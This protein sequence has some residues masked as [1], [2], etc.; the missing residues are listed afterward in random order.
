MPNKADC[1]DGT[2]GR[3]PCDQPRARPSPSPGGPTLVFLAERRI[4]TQ[5]RSSSAGGRAKQLADHLASHVRVR[6]NSLDAPLVI[7]IIGP[8]GAGKSTVFNTLAGRP[9]SRTGVLRP[10]TRV[11]VLCVHPDDREPLLDG[12][13][14]G[15]PLDH[16]NLIEDETI[17]PGLA[18][19]DAPDI[20]SIEHANRNLADRFVEAADL[21][22]FVT[23]AT[24]YADQVPW[25]V[26]ER[27]RQRGLPL[28]FIVNCMPPDAADRGEVIRDVRRLLVEAG[29][30]DA[31][32]GG[33]MARAP[34]SEVRSS[35]ARTNDADGAGID[36]LGIVEGEV[37]PGGESVRPA[38]LA[39][40]QRTIAHLRNDREARAA[41]AARALMG[42]LAGLGELLDRVADDGEHEDI[43]VE[44]LR[45]TLTHVFDRRLKDLRS[46]LG[47]GTFLR[48][49]ALRHWQQFVGADQIT[50]FFSQGIGRVRGAIAAI[51]RPA[52]APV[53]EVQAATTEDLLAVAR[54]E[55]A[56]AA[57][58]VAVAWSDDPSVR[59][60]IA[61][62]PT[63]WGTS[64]GFDDRL[65]SRLDGWIEGIT[66]GIAATGRPKRELARG[67]SIG[68]NALG[69]GVMLATFVHTG[70]L[71]GAEVGVAAAMG[72][73]Q[74]QTPRGV[75]RRGRPWSS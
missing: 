3:V 5:P 75:V 8:T 56:E 50:R 55:A 15:V 54:S 73:P 25:S 69:T 33:G 12:T 35:D 61:A 21:C 18:L 20:D 31:L 59:D 34:A 68:V 43:D 1:V 9:A 11:A 44:V 52:T 66:T 39:P 24:R 65:R 22:L 16:M 72:L 32:G 40:I 41:L 13:L 70:G 28:T 48:E 57:R 23:T 46:E 36:V 38:A 58:L 64:T 30:S 63:L 74:P 42:S 14:K 60:D 53:S 2:S 6:T 19:V 4:A 49:E 17:E 7:L 62:D 45:R 10:T 26:L 71:T 29:L 67:A 47:R 51:F 37:E 27:I